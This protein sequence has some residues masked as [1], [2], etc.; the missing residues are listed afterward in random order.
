L[1][2]RILVDTS[3]WIEFFRAKSEVGDHLE[4]LLTQNAVWTCGVV[5]YEVL[6]GI[7]SEN[8]KSKLRSMLTDLPYIEMRKA[9]WERA[10]EFAILAKKNGLTLPLS[11]IF[12][13]AIALEND[14]SIYTLD[15]H[16]EQVPN[17][18]L[19]KE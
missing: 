5:L 6:Q 14:L 12:I 1:K 2:N 18:K 19:Y 13:A 16:F 11:D 8:E 10:A 17:L 15:K 9:T 4:T 7:K 3:I